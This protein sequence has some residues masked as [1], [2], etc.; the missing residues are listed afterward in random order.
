MN[1]TGTNRKRIRQPEDHLNK[2]SIR[3]GPNILCRNIINLV[4]SSNQINCNR[5]R[6]CALW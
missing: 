4:I 5:S 2:I 3:D 6:G 1:L